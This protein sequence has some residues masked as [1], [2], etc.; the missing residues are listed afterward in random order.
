MLRK[1]PEVIG[2][3]LKV[4]CFTGPTYQLYFH[5]CHSTSSMLKWF[6]KLNATKTFQQEYKKTLNCENIINCIYMQN[7]CV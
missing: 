7:Q 3:K 2:S 1:Y 5:C 4:I 6:A